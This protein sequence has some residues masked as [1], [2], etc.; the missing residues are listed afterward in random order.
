MSV[1]RDAI[2]SETPR[3]SVKRW[4]FRLDRI[5]IGKEVIGSEEKRQCPKR[6]PPGRETPPFAAAIMALGPARAHLRNEPA[7]H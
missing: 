6:R 4:L 5:P 1:L 7:G 3:V 2:L